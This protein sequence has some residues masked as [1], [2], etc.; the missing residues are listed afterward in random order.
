MRFESR[1][2]QFRSCSR[3]SCRDC[4]DR[5]RT[6]A[7]EQ[8]S[9]SAARTSAAI[10][11]LS[12]VTARMRG[13]PENEPQDLSLDAACRPRSMPLPPLERTVLVVAA[14]EAQHDRLVLDAA[15]DVDGTRP[16]PV[17]VAQGRLRVINL[18]I[19][20]TVLVLQIKFAAILVVS[21]ADRDGRAPEI[22][23][24]EEQPLLDLLETAALDLVA[25][26]LG[27]EPVGEQLVLFAKLRGEKLV[28]EGDV[29]VDPAYE[30]DLIAT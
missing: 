25:I 24:G 27:V 15:F 21:V 5:S 29:V 22:G 26:R 12:P 17:Y 28:D 19:G 20:A 3:P 18:Q 16:E 30:E 7:R 2:P 10:A 23:Q 14:V 4:K 13:S 8:P 1:A 11:N 6:S 9:E